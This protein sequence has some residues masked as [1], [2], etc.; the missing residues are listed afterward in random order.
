M[1]IQDLPFGE[2]EKF[3]AVV[4]IPQ[5]SQDKYEYDETL[6]TI[7]LD[8]VLYGS[9]RYPFNYGFIPETRAQ[10]GDHADVVLLSTNPL[11]PGCVVAARPVGFMEM[12][13]SGDI[14]NK[15]IAVP[16]ADPR[17]DYIKDLADIPPHLLKEM[18]NFFE[19][20]K[21]LQNKKV[22]IKGF[23]NKARALKELEETR[24]A[25]QS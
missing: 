24:R 3:N 18:Q 10:D 19:T 16:A 14:D 6:H 13:D 7:K 20:Y 15:I 17:F 23:E 12:I 25:Y 2:P 11:F 21:L 5:G 22:E 9:Q 8:R 1:S 4:E